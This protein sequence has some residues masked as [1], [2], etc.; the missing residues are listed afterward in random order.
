MATGLAIRGAPQGEG[1]ARILAREARALLARGVAPEE[2]LI[3]Y[4]HWSDEAELALETLRAWGLPAHAEVPRPLQGEPAASALRLAASIPLQDWETELIVRL[5]RHGQFRPAWPGADRLEPGVRGLDDQGH[6][7]LPWFRAV[8]SRPRPDSMAQ[9][10]QTPAEERRVQAA[11]AIAERLIKV[12][13]PLDRPRPWSDQA[14]ELR[15]VAGELGMDRAEESTL[16]RLWDALDDQ[17]DMLDRLGRGD[18][19][20]S[21]AAFTAEVDAILGE[22]EIVPAAAS[23]SIRLAT[24]DQAEGRGPSMSSSPTSPRGPSRPGRPSSRSWRWGRSTSRTRRA[25]CSSL[26]RCSGSSR[27]SVRPAREWSWPIPRPI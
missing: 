10:D 13:V 9:P 4:R 12:L 16:E 2:I 14:A 25:G 23:G 3:V 27:S 18:E 26:A 8:A 20:W 1:V 17:T 6:P 19:P 15:R 5:L 22:I 24:V 21:W 11:R 7:G